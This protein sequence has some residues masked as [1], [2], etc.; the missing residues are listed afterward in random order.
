MHKITAEL[1]LETKKILGCD[2][3][4]DDETVY[5]LLPF[6]CFDDGQG[7]PREDIQGG[8]LMISFAGATKHCLL[9]FL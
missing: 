8:S 2:G 9:A 6:L 4:N 3:I 7:S 5:I 1:Q